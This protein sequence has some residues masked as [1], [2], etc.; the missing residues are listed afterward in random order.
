VK[1]KRVC[2]ESS[3]QEPEFSK[4]KAKQTCTFQRAEAKNLGKKLTEK[5]D[6]IVRLPLT[7]STRQTKGIMM[8][9][10]EEHM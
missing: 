5:A 10:N 2:P 7:G 4:A 3:E 8:L 1:S 6:F 9:W